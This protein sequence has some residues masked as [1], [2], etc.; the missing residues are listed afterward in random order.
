MKRELHTQKQTYKMKQL[1]VVLKKR[2]TL[3][4]FNQS[5]QQDGGAKQEAE[6][7]LASLAI[8]MGISIESLTKEGI[9]KEALLE[10]I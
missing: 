3:F 10:Q 1:S 7:S 5:Q 4:H 9:T 2:Q 8:S 6:Q